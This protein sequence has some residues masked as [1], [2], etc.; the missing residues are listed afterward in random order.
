MIVCTSRFCHAARDIPTPV[1]KILPRIFRYFVSQET[2]PHLWGKWPVITVAIYILRD[3][4]TSVGKIRRVF[5]ADTSNETS[6]HLWGKFRDIDV[7]G[8]CPGDIP[9][10]VGEIGFNFSLF[11]SSVRHP[12]TCGE[13]NTANFP[14]DSIDEASLHLWG[15]YNNCFRI[16]PL[17]GDIPT[18]VG[19]IQSFWL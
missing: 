18:S 7:R 14:C 5:D 1:G 15:K 2:S 11:H 12:H 8:Q 10:S 9:T 17:D 6:P 3:I 4:P 16:F 13:N 19:K